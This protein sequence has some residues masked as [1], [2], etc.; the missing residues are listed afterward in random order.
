MI[1]SLLLTAASVTT[2]KQQR[3][4][5]SAS[6]FFFAQDEKLFLVTGRHV[7]IDEGRSQFPSITAGL[8]ELAVPLSDRMRTIEDFGENRSTV[9]K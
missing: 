5:T 2:Y 6:S 7:M 1:E 8:L 3:P 9:H 4:L